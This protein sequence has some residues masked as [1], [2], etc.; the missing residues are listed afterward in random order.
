[1]RDGRYIVLYICGQKIENGQ[2]V[3]RLKDKPCNHAEAKTVF[4]S[5]PEEDLEGV[6]KDVEIRPDGTVAIIVE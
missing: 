1:M 2:V 5:M 3:Y 4:E 6:P